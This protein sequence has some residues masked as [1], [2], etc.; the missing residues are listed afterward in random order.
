MTTG[1]NFVRSW[2][3]FK[4]HYLTISVSGSGKLVILSKDGM[5]GVMN[6]LDAVE[7]LREKVS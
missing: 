5:N 7:G 6:M 1:Y 3:I 4:N 2:Y